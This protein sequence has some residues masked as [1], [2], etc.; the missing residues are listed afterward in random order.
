M[1]RP[2]IRCSSI[3]QIMGAAQS[4]PD[5]APEHIKA[6]AASKKR[7]D[8]DKKTL[9]EYKNSIL[10]ASAKSYLNKLAKEAVYNY[11]KHL[12]IKYFKKGIACEDDLIDLANRVFFMFLSKNKERRSNELITGEPDLILD[13]AIWD[14]K[15]AW[16]LD[17]FPVTPEEAH[18]PDY[19][20]QLRGYLHLFDKQH[21]RI[22]YGL[23]DT[24]EELYRYEQADLHI[25]SHLPPN[26]RITVC[27]YVRDMEKERL[28][29]IKL[30]KAQQYI[31]DQMARIQAAHNY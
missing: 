16:S 27:D 26:M 23:V 10:S 25:V 30:E 8:D 3:G 15:N 14:V 24:P 1:N 5:D 31:I 13:D 21:A 22:V 4:I 19:E 2:L 9:E 12:E 7:T 6:I 20:W 28:M 18:N 17:T 11:R 29:L